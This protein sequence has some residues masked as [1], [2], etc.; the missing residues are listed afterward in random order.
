[1]FGEA[2]LAPNQLLEARVFVRLEAVLGDQFGSDGWFVGFHRA[3]CNQLSH[4]FHPSWPG[5]SRPSTS[6]FRHVKTWMPGTRPGMTAALS[7]AASF[8][9]AQST[10]PAP[11]GHIWGR[12]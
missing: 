5:L 12:A 4:Q 6:Y 10:R 9:R 11:A 8:R 3:R 7:P 2:R 1:E